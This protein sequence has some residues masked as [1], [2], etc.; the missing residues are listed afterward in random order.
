[1]T[2]FGIHVPRV[3]LLLCIPGVILLVGGEGGGCG[4]SEGG[5]G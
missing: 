5:G 3:Y 1:M 2:R 4:G